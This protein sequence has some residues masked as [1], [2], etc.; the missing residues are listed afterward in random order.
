MSK[1]L[2]VEDEFTMRKGIVLT[3]TQNNHIVKEADNGLQ[4]I[5]MLSKER[6]DLVITDLK[7]S[8][9]NGIDVL[10]K[11]KDISSDTGVI[12]ITAYGTIENAVEAIKLGADDFISKPFYADEL[13]LKVARILEKQLLQQQHQHLCMENTALKEAIREKYS[14]ENIIGNS[15]AM[16]QVFNLM[17]RLIEDGAATVIIRGESGTGKELVAKAIHYNSLRKKMPFIA[18]N[19]G[20]IPETLLESEL[21]G[22][23]KGAFTDAKQRTL[24][25]FELAHQGSIF[26]DEIGDIS[27]TRLWP[28]YQKVICPNDKALTTM[29]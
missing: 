13:M 25:K 29:S 4:A 1:I 11:V 19:C 22:H 17:E 26:L 9:I 16:Q 18:V 2:V 21:F 8:G 20:S 24:G 14:F 3:L 15:Q 6:F 28:F 23:E 12:I 5:E 7:M 10:K 27:F